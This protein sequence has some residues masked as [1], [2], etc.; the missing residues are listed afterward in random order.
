MTFFPNVPISEVT[1]SNAIEE[2]EPPKK[3]R[4]EVVE[5]EESKADR[6]KIEE[7]IEDTSPDQGI[8]IDQTNKISSKSASFI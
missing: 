6:V 7:I 1:H 5:E 4:I 2:D 8:G 3:M